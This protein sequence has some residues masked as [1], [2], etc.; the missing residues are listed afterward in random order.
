MCGTGWETRGG[1]GTLERGG[2]VGS[3][4]CSARYR[5]TRWT[6]SR[7]REHRPRDRGSSVLLVHLL[8]PEC[9]PVSARPPPRE[10]MSERINPFRSTPANWLV[11]MLGA[12]FE[13]HRRLPTRFPTKLSSQRVGLVSLDCV[14]CQNSEFI[15]LFTV[16]I[17]PWPESSNRRQKRSAV[18]EADGGGHGGGHGPA[19]WPK[20]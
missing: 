8:R 12:C 17:F 10:T 7:G 9:C 20:T 1:W 4:W 15:A 18:L 3:R 11:R 2:W 16:S 13:L 19:K 6:A 5:S 14:P